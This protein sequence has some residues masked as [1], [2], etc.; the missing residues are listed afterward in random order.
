MNPKDNQNG[1]ATIKIKVKDGDNAETEDTFLVHVAAVNDK[2]VANDTSYTI[3]EDSGAHTTPGTSVASDVDIAT[4]ADEITLTITTQALHGT[5]AVVDG[6]LV[7]TPNDNWNG[8]DSFVY[9]ATDKLLEA[10]TGLVSITVTQAND[11]PVPDTDSAETPEGTPVTIDVLEGDTDVDKDPSLNANPGAEV[12]SIS[13]SGGGLILPSRGTIAIVSG[14]IVYTPTGNNNGE[15]TFEYYCTDG[16]A[17]VK[18]QVT[19]MVKQVNDNP[20]AVADTVAMDEDHDSAAVDVMKNDTDVDIDTSVNMDVAYTRAMFKVTGATVKT[21]DSGTAEVM[22][23]YTIVFHP[24]ANWFGTAVV[25]YTLDDGKGGTA[26][27]TLTVTVRSV[28]DAPVFDTPTVDMNL[29]EDL[30]NG[31]SNIVVNDVETVKADLAVT[32]VSSTN[33]AL[34]DGGCVSITSGTGGNRTVTVNPKDNQNGDA[35]IKIKVKDGDNA[36]TEDTFLV[37]VAA[38]NDKPVAND[39]SY[40]IAEDSGAHTT[41]GTSVASDVDIATNADEI[42]LTITTQAV[43]GTAAVVDGNLVYTPNENWNGTD[44]FV[45]TATDKLLEADT[46]LVSITVTQVNDKPVPDTDSA[47]TPEG[48]PVTIDV[49]EGDTDVDKD[50]SLNANPGA[51]VLSISLSGGGLILPSRGTIAIVSGKIVYTPTGNNNGEDTFEYYCTDGEAPVKAQVTVMVKQV[52]DNPVAV[53]DTVAMDEDHDSAAVDVMKNDTDV[54]ID[55]SVNM[56][57]AYTRAMF[58]V[59]GATVKTADSGT[60]EVM[61]DYTIVFHPAANWFGTANVEY[62]LDDGKGGTATGTLTVT[63]R[64]VNDAPVF[65]TP[66]ADMNLTEDLAN[67]E[68]N[69]VVND[70]ETVKADLAVTF[71]SST[72]P[73]L[74][75]GGCVSI[76]SGTGGNRTVTV[77][78]KDNQNGDATIKI[79]VKDGD[80]A[81]T[82]DTF[83]VHV[84]AVNDKPVAN[85]TSYTI[86]EDSGAHTTPGT[87]VASDVDIATNADEITLTITT[88]AVHG[89]AAVVDGNLVYTPNDN[90]NGTDSFVYTATDKLLEADTGLVS[91]T[92]T[93]V[94]DKPVPDTDSAETPEGTPV[95]IDV[96]EGDTDV[97]KDPSLNANPGAEVLS[98]SLSGGGLTL[99][100][101]GTIAIVDGKI[102]YTPTGN[103]NGEDTFEYYCTDGEAPVKA[104]VTVMVKQVN[105]NP[106]ANDDSGSTPD[107]TPVSVN[108]LANDTDVDIDTS[109]NMDKAFTRA[110][111][112]VSGYSFVG[113]STGTLSEENGVITYTPELNFTGTQD[114]RYTLSDGNGGTAIGTLTIRVDAQNDAPVAR[115]DE[116]NTAEDKPVTRNMLTN[117]TDQDPGDTISFVKFLSS[118]A[119]LPGAFETAADGTL[120]FTPSAN[121]HGSFS[122]DYQMKDAAGLTAS[123]TITVIVSAVND[124]PVGADAD[125]ATSEDTA[126]AIDIGALISDADIATDA[127]ELT[128]TV[129]AKDGPAHGKLL[130][131]GTTITYTPD[132]NFNGL[133]S[134][135]YTVT[136][137]AGDSD[138]GKISLT[139]NAVNDA[140]ETNPDADVIDEDTSITMDVAGNDEDVDTDDLLNAVPQSAPTLFSVGGAEHGTVKMEGGK[141][142]YT[143]NKDYNG[144]DSFTYQ[145]S[146]GTLKASGT[147]SLTIRQVNDPVDA[148]DDAASVNDGD[149]VTIDALKNDTDVDTDASLNL[150]AAHARSTFAIESVG[151]PAHGTAEIVSGKIVYT[152]DATYA[153]ADSF[154][155]RMTDGHET[156]D[157]ATV[158]ITVL[159]ANDPPETPVV[160]TPKDG[161]RA[162]GASTVTVEWTC[163]DI[164][165]DALTYTLEYYD[166]AA[167]KQAAKSLTVTTYAFAI[168]ASLG[169]TKDLQF[170]VTAT[171]GE[172]TT[173]YGYS[174]KMSVDRD[175]P[176][177]V[178]IAMKTADG[179]AYTAGEWT[180]QTVTVSATGADDLNPVTFQYAQD[181]A[182]YAAGE[183]SIVLQ[184]VHNVYILATDAFDNAADF[185]PYLARVDKQAPLAAKITE[186][187]SGSGI[188]LT[189]ALQTDPGGSGNDYLL[190][191]DN[192][193][194]AARGAI[195][196][197][198]AKNGVYSFTIFDIAGNRTVFTYTVSN[199]DA[200]KPTIACDAG[201]YAIGSATQSSIRAELTFTDAESTL[202]TRGYQ[203]SNSASP[204]GAYRSYTGALTM[205]DPGTYYIHAYAKNAFG[206]TA[207]ETF[208]PFVIEA[209]AAAA[210][211]PAPAPEKGDVKVDVGDITDVPGE[212]VSIR[213]PGQEWSQTITLE[214][215]APGDYMVEV[216]NSD[217]T[218]H[219]VQVHVTVRDIV[220]RSLRGADAGTIAAIAAAAVGLAALAFFLL[221][222]GHNITVRVIGPFGAEE[223]KLRTLRRMSFKKKLLLIKLSEAQ[224]TGGKRAEIRIA[225]QLVKSMRGN[226]FA[227]ELRGEQVLREQVPEDADESIRRTIIL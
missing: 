7:Y 18:A 105:D 124:K 29:T 28:N 39:T 178:T 31:E 167:W 221:F 214:D 51:E 21:A 182:A 162:G 64:S 132:G 67:G 187:V 183:N 209:P 223:K 88:Q 160:S 54:D 75:D 123:A 73:A 166:G 217:G 112:N 161:D 78:P 89:T 212:P 180:N 127:D 104:Q 34:V 224:V 33:P 169:S 175:A 118:T 147:V 27:G 211:T 202:T 46:G 194:M 23:D 12:L 96:L 76:T 125:A 149:A 215:V 111:F 157:T 106:V 32:F 80:N 25:E 77:N 113:S 219:T 192:T 170:R 207:F 61:G 55:T 199:V 179:R 49:L 213:L 188:L 137:K 153:G 186:S 210:A 152:A 225:K 184:G 85:D 43:H 24:A 95:T 59:T 22:G 19:V 109:V 97:D 154:T 35:T 93:Q 48:T 53:A 70:V 9:T 60:A 150:G 120:T 50:P 42:T 38:V 134:F 185:G 11:K 92:V 197:Q 71:V 200:S 110:T 87:S 65:D 101:R 108:V 164:D 220:A 203:L 143:P 79:K 86:A 156:H 45:Y 10:D 66:T 17:P 163:F 36:E 196:F 82:E 208:G 122:I 195:Q 216:M 47:E 8:T 26:T 138:T 5:A 119:G 3:A 94:N 126:K 58:K 121:Y 103:N 129:A 222:L 145:I 174:G 204:S 116:M 107:E 63:V 130:V 173:D 193:R 146:D 83:L 135:V 148:I 84:A 144:T 189:L 142:V 198:A 91:I 181:G 141:A 117:D 227:I 128:V 40:T 100:T 151:T 171:D 177:S 6:N 218:I 190:L 191:P 139:I 14:K 201:G 74:V 44:S 62:T 165:G 56:D 30:A 57:V 4:N 115:A 52:N 136:D 2:P 68:S 16:E 205:S 102:V 133:D 172:F 131:S 1:D 159:A 98:I 15:D 168:P 158:F 176:L 81:E 69:I 37:H 72:N 13:L 155:Y 140:P 226:E 206:L 99:P 114:I 41:P 20:V 90:W